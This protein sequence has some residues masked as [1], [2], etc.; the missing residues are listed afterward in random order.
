MHRELE[1]TIRK[2]IFEV[3]PQKFTK[4]IDNRII[5]NIVEDKEEK[6]ILNYN[7]KFLDI[8]AKKDRQFGFK[9]TLENGKIL[10][11][12]GDE[13]FNEKLKD[14]VQNVD[15]LLHEAFCMDAEA[16]IFK[17][18]EK[19][20]STAKTASKI[21]MN[22]NVKNLILYHTSDNNLKNRKKLYTKEAQEYFKGNIYVP[23]DLDI[24]EL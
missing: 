19:M 9:T 10:V 12:L 1:S 20:H 22:L 18:Y 16:E 14:E 23:D 21:A 8:L 6:K 15:W 13:T 17:P 11:F 24:I 3:L 2:I 7:I 4:L 5:F